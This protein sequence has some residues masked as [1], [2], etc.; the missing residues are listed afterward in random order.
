MALHVMFGEKR[1]TNRTSRLTLRIPTG[2]R[3]N[4]I[5]TYCDYTGHLIMADNHTFYG[6]IKMIFFFFTVQR[7]I[8]VRKLC[9]VWTPSNIASRSL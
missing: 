7:K 1:K 6:R 8:Y 2:D 3:I 9:I 4:N 5:A